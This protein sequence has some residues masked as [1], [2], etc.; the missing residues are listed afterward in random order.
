MERLTATDRFNEAATTWDE[1]PSRVKLA[2]EVAAEIR[3]RLPL[4]SADEVLDFGC[5]T[6]LVTLSLQPHVGRVTGADSSQGMLDELR[7]K[8]RA[9]RL[10]NVDT[11]LLDATEPLPLDRR[12]HVIV[13]SMA[14]HHVAD[15][16]T[17]FRRFYELLLEGGRIA[18]ADLDREDGSFHEDARGVYHHGFDRDEVVSLLSQAGFDALAMATA[19]VARRAEREYPVFL[20]TGRRANGGSR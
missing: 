13:S 12:F 6:G 8:I 10:V 3:R 4:S 14:L 2:L 7:E 19:T 17:L 15:V 20:V 18:L 1:N 9:Q 11:A 5:G 16:A